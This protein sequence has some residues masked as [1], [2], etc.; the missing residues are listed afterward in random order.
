MTNLVPSTPA[1]PLS[2]MDVSKREYRGLGLWEETKC[3]VWCRRFRSLEAE[4]AEFSAR[5]SLP[6][7]I[8]RH[9]LN[10]YFEWEWEEY[11]DIKLD[12]EEEKAS[13]R[14]R[15]A[16]SKNLIVRKHYS[17][18]FE[19]V[20]RDVVAAN[21]TK[22]VV[23]KGDFQSSSAVQSAKAQLTFD[24]DIYYRVLNTSTRHQCGDYDPRFRFLDD[25]SRAVLLLYRFA[26][27]VYSSCEQREDSEVEHKLA[28]NSAKKEKD[29]GIP[30][31]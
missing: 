26:A 27:K 10:D 15:V 28:F 18:H 14:L 3:L 9:L 1:Q 30:L 2:L 29:L 31:L 11:E 16:R 6:A 12:K 8:L 23:M 17:N 4:A 5:E 21:D 13:R 24:Y 25:K 20:Y 22:V 7:M 19:I